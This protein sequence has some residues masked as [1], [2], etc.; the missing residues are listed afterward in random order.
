[1]KRYLRYEVSVGLFVIAAALI[2]GYISLK[3]SRMRVRDGIDVNLIFAHASGLVKDSPVSIAGVEVGY[4]KGIGLRSGGA[5]VTARVSRAAGL[6]R[7]ATASIRSRSLLGEQ[8]LELTPGSATG[9]LLADGDTITATVTPFQIDQMIS[10]CGSLTAGIDPARAARL[11]NAVA[12][13][14]EAAR[15][16]MR[17]ADQLLA[18]LA[19]LDGPA[20][21]DYIQQ[22][23][24]RARLF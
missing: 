15:R 2:L 20:L 14:P 9:P 6:R 21:R 16:I 19:A 1:M 24:I 7:G 23:K 13:D 12:D 17:N 11:V 10:W 8:Y 5:M 3:I 18:R 22:L 4:V